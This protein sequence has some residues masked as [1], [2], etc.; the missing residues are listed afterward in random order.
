M[1]IPLITQA[2][3]KE[4]VS[5][6][7]ETGVM[8]CLTRRAHRCPVGSIAGNPGTDG[9]LKAKFEGRMYLIHRLAW[10]Y[11]TGDWPRHQI[12]HINGNP[13]DNRWPNLRDVPQAINNQNQR[14]PQRINKTGFLGVVCRDGRYTSKLGKHLG[15]FNTGE[16]AHAAYLKAKRANHPGCTI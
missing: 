14:K 10:L 11:M 12:D 3:L 16:E 7:P 4:L 6:D 8:L 15:S 13:A 1:D 9:H 2:R 5:Y